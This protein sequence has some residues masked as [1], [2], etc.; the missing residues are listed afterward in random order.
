VSVW[1]A[2]TGDPGLL[3]AHDVAVAAALDHLERF[4][5]TTRV[6]VNGHRQHPDTLGLTM[7]TFSQTTSR[8]DDPQLHTH[9]V[10]SAK[11]QTGDGRWM[12]LDARYLKRNQ[13]MLGGLYQS[14]LR[15]ELTHRYGV[16]WEP[17]VNGQA[18]LAGAPPEL[19]AAFSERASQVDAAL[20]VKLEE[21]QQR[22]GRE[23]TR[24]ERAALC[25]EASADTRAHKSGN[26]VSDLRTRWE[27]EAET[28]GWTPDRLD[29]AL[30]TTGPSHA[31]RRAVTVEEVVDALSVA[32]STWTRADVMKAI[33]DH[34]EPVPSMDGRRWAAALERACAQAMG[35]CVDLD[36]AELTARRRSS[37]HRSVWIEP[38]APHLTSE[39]ILVEEERVL[40]WAMEA[41]AA[42][43]SPSLT[44]DNDGLDVLQA[45]AACAVAGDDRLVL[46]VGPAGAGKTTTLRRG[47]DDLVASDRAVFGLA[48]SAK[49]ARVLEHE[50]GLPSDT[51]AKL[52]HEWQ[53]TDRPPLDRYR[54]PAGATIIVDEAGMAGTSSL[55]QLVRLADRQQWRLVL[56]GD[57][58]Q[59]QAVGRG[60]LFN[61]LSTTGRVHELATI[62]RFNEPWEATASLHLRAGNPKALDAYEAH[63]RI[64]A[65]S[66]DDHLHQIAKSSVA[67]T[68][69]G[70]TVAITAATND[71]VSALNYAIQRVRL[72]IGDL[73]PHDAAPI[74]GNQC[75]CV[76]DVVVTR[77]DDRSLRTDAGEPVRNRDLWHVGATLPD[78]SLTVS[79]LAGHGSITLPADYVR[80]YVRLGYAAT[81]HGNQSVTVDVGIQLVSIGTTHR[82][83]YVG[84]TRGRE[85][86][87]MYVVTESPDPAEARSVLEAVIAVDRVD[88][89]AV[90]QRRALAGHHPPSPPALDLPDVIPAWLPPYGAAL[91]ARRDE[92]LAG[93][94]QRAEDRAH[95]AAALLELQPAL[96]E[97]RAAWRHYAERIAAIERELHNHLRPAM[98]KADRNATQ[99]R[100]GHRHAAVRAAKRAATQVDQAQARIAEIRADGSAAEGAL[101]AVD[102]QVRQL[103][104]V[105]MGTF[106]Q[107]LDQLDRLEIDGIESLVGA[108]DTWSRWARGHPVAVADLAEAVAKLH[109]AAGGPSA[110]TSA[111]SPAHGSDWSD[112]L[113]PAITTLRDWGIDTGHDGPVT[114]TPH[115]GDGW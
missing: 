102:H 75:A 14:V 74:A 60:G 36:P 99:A 49:A 42:E 28:F 51:M 57:P 71:H 69:E 25:R 30:T 3:D 39:A 113:W 41:Q 54:L 92:L 79:N 61:E 32:G 72:T 55:D 52:L 8:A 53:R 10:I 43:S 15:A 16:A 93:L 46:V 107:S 63:D 85:D 22:E 95:A 2:I 87:R 12:A 108:I 18:E 40:T 82:G 103:A 114:P 66:I 96:D 86:N 20:A 83:L 29:E 78:G 1:W 89:P 70:T 65:G 73:D 90:T 59:L 45:A 97:A 81:E 23:P 13:R 106:S 9:A 62:H 77:R 111:I 105:A 56:V 91:E 80:Q 101:A 109:G 19:L 38:T 44:V 76:G 11:V 37:D 47:V 115:L 104:D 33:S 4:G 5:S 88:V 58:R 68:R 98:W 94:G 26:R 17:I 100:F 48:P 24:W 67:L 110:L 64:V 84:A 7:A 27:A 6:R 50:T 112:L 21:F 34:Q 35:H 31:D